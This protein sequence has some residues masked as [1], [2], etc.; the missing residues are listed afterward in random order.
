MMIFGF[1]TG[2]VVDGETLYLLELT[3]D[4]LL[5]KSIGKFSGFNYAKDVSREIL[6]EVIRPFPDAE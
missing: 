5:I 1:L 6:I 3:D 2:Y 4:R